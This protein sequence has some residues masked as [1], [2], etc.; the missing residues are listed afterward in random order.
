[1]TSIVIGASSAIARAAIQRLLER[2]QTVHAISQRPRPVSLSDERLSWWQ[3]RHEAADIE[4]QVDQLAERI[5]DAPIDRVLICNGRLHSESIDVEK[6]LDDL[7]VESFHQLMDSNALIP[8]LWLR[9]L[10]PLLKKHD[11]RIAVFSARIGSIGDNRLGGWY[12]YRASKAALNM[13]LKT[14]A[15][16]YARIAKG[17][18]LVAFHPGTTDTPLSKPFQAKVPKGKLFTPD[19]VASRLLDILDTVEADRTLSFL[20]WDGQAIDW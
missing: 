16:E 10:L 6:K 11:T 5:A 15:V 20:D 1:M 8:A 14:A 13:L 17:V 18:K 4:A 9:S 12:S 19:F 2:G 3:C 7:Q